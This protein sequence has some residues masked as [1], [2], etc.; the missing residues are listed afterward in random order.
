MNEASIRAFLETNHRE[1][2]SRQAMYD[3]SNQRKALTGDFLLLIRRYLSDLPS[4][5]DFGRR[6]LEEDEATHRAAVHLAAGEYIQRS[7]LPALQRRERR[8]RDD[9]MADEERMREAFWKMRHMDQIVSVLPGE[10]RIARHAIEL[11]EELSRVALEHADAAW[12]FQVL[13]N[14][15][16]DLQRD[17]RIRRRDLERLYEKER[18]AIIAQSIYALQ[19]LRQSQKK[20]GNLEADEEIAREDLMSEEVRHRSALNVSILRALRDLHHR[21]SL[22]SR[23]GAIRVPD[24]CPFMPPHG[25]CPLPEHRFPEHRRPPRQ[26]PVFTRPPSAASSRPSMPQLSM[27]GFH[28]F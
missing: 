20:R 15:F 13:Q 1:V 24:A 6:H 18:A 26:P 8:G 3:L 5:E 21:Q 9:I 22:G 4:Q 19:G 11:D 23:V 12:S 2:V 7:L 25:D 16:T 27:H 28:P 14:V 10:E 17:E